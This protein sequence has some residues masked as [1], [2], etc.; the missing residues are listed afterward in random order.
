MLVIYFIQMNRLLSD[1]LQGIVKSWIFI[2]DSPV[3]N[4]LVASFA[5]A[6]G[7]MNSILVHALGGHLLVALGQVAEVAHELGLVGA[8]NVFAR[9]KPAETVQNYSQLSERFL[10]A[11]FFEL[12]MLV[13]YLLDKLPFSC[14][15]G[16]RI[17]TSFCRLS[18]HP[19]LFPLVSVVHV[20][21]FKNTIILL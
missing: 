6:T 7:V 10:F 13:A 14:S 17:V 18:S 19:V 16:F 9:V 21:S 5:E 8:V 3:V 11:L 1:F 12:A 20:N 15:Y 2:D 4:L